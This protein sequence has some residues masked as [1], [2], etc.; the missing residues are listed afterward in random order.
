MLF[1][2]SLH[3]HLDDDLDGLHDPA[4]TGVLCLVLGSPVHE[5]H[6]CTGWSL[7]KGREGDE[8]TGA[9]LL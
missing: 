3:L 7:V 2:M 4:T 6:G 8:G 5:R 9:S 1:A